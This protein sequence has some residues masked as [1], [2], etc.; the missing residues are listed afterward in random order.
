M[1]AIQH[2]VRAE[3]NGEEEANDVD[4]RLFFKATL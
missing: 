3:T 1:V 2:S 4:E